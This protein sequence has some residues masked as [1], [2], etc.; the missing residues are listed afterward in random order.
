MAALAL[1]S[2]ARPMAALRLG[3]ASYE[4]DKPL[5]S[6]GLSI[7]LIASHILGYNHSG[8]L[9]VQ[10]SGFALGATGHDVILAHGVRHSLQHDARR[11]C[12]AARIFI[13]PW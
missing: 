8:S 9:L 5:G 4:P 12:A 6:T 7:S 2:V 13:A 11:L 10:P 1:T 3:V